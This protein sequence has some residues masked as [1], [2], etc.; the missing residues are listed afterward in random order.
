MPPQISNKVS[1]GKD[2]KLIILVI[3]GLMLV[4]INSY[5]F[6]KSLNQKIGPMPEELQE[7]L[8]QYRENQ[9]STTSISE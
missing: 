6:W 5:F 8:K 9:I 4:I 1:E 7:N 3:V 2:K